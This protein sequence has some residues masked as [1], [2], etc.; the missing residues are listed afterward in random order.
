MRQ[1][2]PPMDAPPALPIES[3]RGPEDF[4]LA[5][6]LSVGLAGR[7]GRAGPRQLMSRQ[8]AVGGARRVKTQTGR[9]RR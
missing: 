3:R 2:S 5:V 8:Q 7:T 6:G 9:C 1:F 4:G